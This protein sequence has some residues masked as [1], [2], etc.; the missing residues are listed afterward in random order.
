MTKL[1]TLALFSSL[2]RRVGNGRWA[3]TL[4]WGR[5]AFAAVLLCSAT[6][7]VTSGQTFKSLLS[8]DETD[9]YRP[10]AG[11]T[12]ATNGNFYGTTEDGGTCTAD[13]YG[14]GTVFEITST[15]K[16]TTLYNFCQQI[17]CTDGWY[18]EGGLIQANDGNFYGTTYLGGSG[19]S[20]G[21][22]G[23][24][25]TIFKI[26]PAGELTTLYSFCQLANCADGLLPAAGLVQAT[27]GN[28]YGTTTDGGAGADA[29]GTVFEITPAGK[30]TTLHT[31]NDVVGQEGLS[32]AAALVQAT[33]G[34]FYGTTSA[35]T[36]SSGATVFAITPAGKLTT[37]HIFDGTDGS[38]PMAALIQATDGNFYGTAAYGGTGDSGGTVFKMTPTG[39]LT[40]LYNFC[41]QEGCPD[42]RNPYG[43][44]VQA[45][46][47]NFYGTTYTGGANGWGA[48]FKI[49][50]AGKLTTV[51][52]FDLSD[53]SYPTAGPIQATNGTLY[54]TTYQGGSSGNCEGGCGTVFALSVGLGPFVETRPTSGKVGAK[55]IILG[56]NLTG[57]TDVTF[58][59]T[60]ATFTVVSSTEIR[61]TVPSDASTGNVQ[62]T[63]PSATLASNVSFHVAP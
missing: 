41:Q 3:S 2:A 26:T 27:N 21:A 25:G 44:L 63:T 16:L 61:T 53:G 22:G 4:G 34:N 42:G 36:G 33:N 13:S 10:M 46:D 59:G 54:G 6:A 62:V 11:L 49:T 24:C 18:P 51:H 56:N 52:S 58:N 47:G 9:G 48:V 32:P 12:Q 30:L 17:D 45:T 43:G 14:C 50:P 57:S 38:E 8:F 5:T 15:G 20:C 35:G 29:I 19:A 40:T 55:V 1:R 28:F 31:F 7:T 60:E 23:G 37:V 39:K